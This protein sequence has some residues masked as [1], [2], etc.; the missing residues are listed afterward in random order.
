[1]RYARFRESKLSYFF[2]RIGSEKRE[3]RV[4]ERKVRIGLYGLSEKVDSFLGEEQ[5]LA[6]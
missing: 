5:I 2:R 3:R 4:S 6:V 1:V